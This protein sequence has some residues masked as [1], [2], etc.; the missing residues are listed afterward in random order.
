MPVTRKP[1][2]DPMA[3]T[4]VPDP[5]ALEAYTRRRGSAASPQAEAPKDVRFTLQI[6][7][8][9]CQQLDEVRRRRPGK[10]SRH[11]WVLEAIAKEIQREAS[12]EAMS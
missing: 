9:L 6:P 12:G 8:L 4:A 10:I 1:T 2:A 7:G 11:Q 5:A 3:E